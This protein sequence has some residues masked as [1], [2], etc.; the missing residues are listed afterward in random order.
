MNPSTHSLA[1][2]SQAGPDRQSTP[3][4]QPYR[5]ERPKLTINTKSAHSFTIPRKPI[6]PTK[7]ESAPLPHAAPTD[8]PPELRKYADSFH[9]QVW[10]DTDSAQ[11]NLSIDHLPKIKRVDFIPK[12][13]ASSASPDTQEPSSADSIQ[14]TPTRFYFPYSQLPQSAVP[15]SQPLQECKPSKIVRKPTKHV[16]HSHFTEHI[17]APRRNAAEPAGQCHKVSSSPW[18]LHPAPPH[19]RINLPL[20]V[21]ESPSCRRLSTATVQSADYLASLFTPLSP[22]DPRKPLQPSPSPAPGSVNRVP[23]GRG[24][25]PR[26]IR[27]GSNE[28]GGRPVFRLWGMHW[29][30]RGRG[31]PV[32]RFYKD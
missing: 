23:Q 15:C 31:M 29:V 12:S 5:H 2:A 11:L 7:S 9:D 28:D 14:K 26:M 24:G 25:G 20:Y 3:S 22:V 18:P 21:P 13:P 10:A 32:G 1:H 30:E 27:E 19:P 8:L 6:R 17:D 4:H 16:K